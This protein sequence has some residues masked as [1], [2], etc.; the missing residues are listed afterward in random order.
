MPL[1]IVDA[2]RELKERRDN[3]EALHGILDEVA[4]DYRVPITEL[5]KRVELSWGCPLETDRERNSAYFGKVANAANT[6]AQAREF[7]RIVY[8]SNLA[9][10]QQFQFW[11][12]NW[13]REIDNALS[14]VEL[15]PGLE[16]IVR[17]LLARGC[18]SREIH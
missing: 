4:A 1:R 14:K 11:E 6:A 8:E 13:E 3:G 18:A 15:D 17:A 5:R 12:V 2:M 7:A 16:L 10:I 9:G